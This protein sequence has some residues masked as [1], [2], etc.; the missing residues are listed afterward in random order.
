MGKRILLFLAVNALIVVTIL[1]VTNILGIRHYVTEQGI[2]YSALLVFSAIVGFT[3]ALISLALSRAMAKWMLGVRVL[4]PDDPN[5]SPDERWLVEEV[6]RLARRAGLTEMPEV[7]IYDSPEVNAFATGPTRNRSLVAVSTGLLENMDKDGVQ[8]V[9]G[10]EVAH[11]ANGDMVT[12]TLLQGVINTFVIFLSRL[13]AYVVSR[14]VREELAGVVH[15]ICIIVFDLLFSILGSI[16]V[17]A[18][19]RHREYHADRGGADL[20]GKEKM[21]HALRLLQQHVNLIDTNHKS[22]QTMKISNRSGWLKLF[23]SHPDL[24]DRIARLERA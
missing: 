22:L 1:L 20:A 7:G 2:D 11:I 23:S 10:H 14:F 12:M 9:L 13:A 4:S 18:Y 5:L 15:F 8:G 6:H 21:I 24:E 16:V 3:G 17:M 19:S